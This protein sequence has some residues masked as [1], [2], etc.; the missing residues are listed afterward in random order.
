MSAVKDGALL[1]AHSSIKPVTSILFAGASSRAVVTHKEQQRVVAN[2]RIIQGFHESAQILVKVYD[3]AVEL[4]SLFSNALI[5]KR[6]RVGGRNGKRPMHCIRRQIDKERLGG[7][8][9]E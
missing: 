1:A 3:H 8:R 5:E 4:G 9:Y 2:L 6:T 7:T